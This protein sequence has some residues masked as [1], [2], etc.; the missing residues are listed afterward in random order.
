M[1]AFSLFSF[2]PGTNLSPASLLDADET[3]LF[4]P[5]VNGFNEEWVTHGPE[6]STISITISERHDVVRDSKKGFST[7]ASNLWDASPKSYYR[8]EGYDF[9]DPD[10]LLVSGPNRTKSRSQFSMFQGSA[11]DPNRKWGRMVRAIRCADV[12]D[13][14]LRVSISCAT[15]TS[16]A[17]RRYFARNPERS[18]IPTKRFALELKKLDELYCNLRTRKNMKSLVLLQ[19]QHAALNIFTSFLELIAMTYTKSRSRD[20]DARLSGL[21]RWQLEAIMSDSQLY[22]EISDSGIE[23]VATIE[24]LLDLV[25]GITEQD[26]TGFHQE[27]ELLIL[28]KALRG[29]CKDIKLRLTRLSD[30][31]EHS[32]K[33][34]SI[35]R[36]LNQSSNVQN[37]TLLATIFLPLSLAA[38]VLSMQSRFKDLGSLLYDFFGVVVL[39]VAIV[40]LLLGIMFVFANVK[41]LESRILKYKAYRQ[42]E[43]RIVLSI[44]ALILITFGAL[45]LA[46]FIVGMFKDVVLGATILGYGTIVLVFGPIVIWII[47][48]GIH[49]IV[50]RLKEGSI[51]LSH[52]IG[53]R[54]NANKEKENDIE[55]DFGTRQRGSRPRNE[56]DNGN[57]TSGLQV[58][59]TPNTENTTNPSE[60]IHSSTVSKEISY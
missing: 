29:C 18:H 10:E 14:N 55:K 45:V 16:P 51:G 19:F 44:L 59:D 8:L 9:L 57:Q 35:T 21:R 49:Q 34:L 15:V 40:L 58:L 7:L 5:T 32:L 6:G 4:E 13:E 25:V 23:L 53:Q 36:E 52:I 2:F 3:E 39:L 17:V 1:D 37:L 48:P 26:S 33:F 30:G 27:A 47:A 20:F 41:E 22:R 54:F 46:S 60:D 56:L 31:L 38:G 42:F 12:G 28:D 24:S 50:R 43:R 11:E